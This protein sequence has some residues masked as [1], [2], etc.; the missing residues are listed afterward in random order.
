MSRDS[1]NTDE[2]EGRQNILGLTHPR[3]VFIGANNLWKKRSASALTAA[4]KSTWVERLFILNET[5]LFWYEKGPRRADPT[6]YDGLGPQHGRVE[7]RHIMSI[8]PVESHTVTGTSMEE[9]WDNGPKYQLEIKH[10]MSDVVVLIG[11]IDQ[12]TIE[13][14]QSALQR[15]IKSASNLGDERT[16]V[17]VS[18]TPSSVDSLLLRPEVTGIL[19]VG[20]LSKAREAMTGIAKQRLEQAGI[21]SQSREDGWSSRT[22]VL[23]DTSLYFFKPIQQNDEAPTLGTALSNLRNGDYIFGRD[24]GYMPLDS[25]NVSFEKATE[26][27]G[28]TCVYIRIHTYI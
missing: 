16:S 24:V 19:A 7:L 11:A 17:S 14:W 28:T 21:L 15:V 5:A 4:V 2:A 3:R 10:I 25:A 12:A 20:T 1:R 18:S 23:T 6:T 13:A 27:D 22:I 9:L 8:R 26:S